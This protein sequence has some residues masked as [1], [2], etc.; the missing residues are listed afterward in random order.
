MCQKTSNERSRM[1]DNTTYSLLDYVKRIFC[2]A[3]FVLTF[4]LSLNG[5]ILSGLS[6]ETI[7]RIALASFAT[8]LAYLAINWVISDFYNSK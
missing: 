7:G 3:V 6:Y 8:W 1:N 4:Y 5:N 2:F